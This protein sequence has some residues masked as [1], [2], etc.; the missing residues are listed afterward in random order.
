MVATFFVIVRLDNDVNEQEEYD[1]SM[2]EKLA[3]DL[4]SGKGVG[5]INDE[6]ENGADGTTTTAGSYRFTFLV[7]YAI[8]LTVALFFFYFLTSTVF[9]SG[10]LGCG[11]LPILGG[12]PYEL[13]REEV[14]N[15]KQS[16]ANENDNNITDKSDADQLCRG[17][18][19]YW[20]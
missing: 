7:G 16:N 5:N 13:W 18:E 2:A 1:A 11:R 17:L 14:R 9:F 4:V 12:R 19:S 20:L 15:K 8:E 3:E 10:I 6:N